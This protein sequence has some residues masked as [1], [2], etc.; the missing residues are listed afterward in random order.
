MDAIKN[1]MCLAAAGMLACTPLIAQEPVDL[2]TVEV[3]GT[4]ASDVSGIESRRLPYR[5]QIL[6]AADFEAGQ[7]FSLPDQL[8]R[9]APGFFVNEAQGN[10]LQ[11]DL[12]FRGFTASP[13]LGLPQGL[14]VYVN[15][16]R[17]NEVFGDTVNFDLL[18][19]DAFGRIE[20]VPGSNP[21]YGLNSLGGAIAIRTKTGFT[22]PG[23]SLEVGGGSFARNWQSLESGGN[24]GRFGYY[25]NLRR[26]DEEG[27]R[28][29]SPTG[30]YQGLGV[31]SFRHD[32]GDLN[33]TLAGADNDLIGNGAI[34]E[35]LAEI[36][37]TAIFTR[38]DRTSNRL[39]FG[40]L[41]GNYFVNDA[42]ELVGNVYFRQ[43]LADSL[44]GDESEFEECEE[45]QN[46]GFLCEEEDDGEEIVLDVGGNPVAF[47]ENREGGA[48][49]TTRTSQRGYGINFQS[50][51]TQPL[52]GRDNR[53]LVGV[54]WDHGQANFEAD[55]ELGRLTDT[56]A[57]AGSGVFAGEPRVRLATQTN[58]IGL[59]LTDTLQL[60][61]RLAL[62]VSGR[63]NFS[64]VQLIDRFGDELS[65]DH[66]FSRFNPAGGFTYDVGS[67]VNFYA[68]YGEST[69]VPTPVELSCADPEQPCRLPNAFLADPPLEQVVAR[70]VEGGLR[71]EHKKLWGG[72]WRWN[73]GYFRTTNDND[74]LFISSGVV[75][76]QGF[77][78]NVGETRREGV[79]LGLEA[80]YGRWRFATAY[81]Y[82]DASFQEDFTVA[83]PNNPRA[84][85][86]GRIP[87]RRG[88]RIPGIPQHLFKFAAEA[89]VVKDA[90]VGLDLLYSGE[91][92][93][94]GDE[95][96]LTAP[97]SDYVVV[98]LRGEYRF[99]R[100]VSL[101]GRLDNVFDEEYE[102]FG[103]YGNA[104]E[105][106]GPRFDGNRFVTPAA[107]RAGWVGVRLRL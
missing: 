18:S 26:F 57:V 83:S 45:A 28:D 10:P 43:N 72:D 15:G 50:I 101:F 38:P 102:T 3:V 96:N 42:I 20:V 85:E 88:D 60:T 36:D 70:T 65:G 56:R 84:D 22:A 75:A 52:A 105:V 9:T 1:R 30:V 100:H 66:S 103:L 7:A 92:F 86:E 64:D 63:Y 25:L 53:L 59:Y 90:T 46:A 34:P 16:V 5:A 55:T 23:H 17:F 106:L 104:E 8:N 78:D 67:G 82:L 11:P 61:D 13:L 71:G 33:L 99:N 77:F 29:F 93:L 48:L 54:G 107:G 76:G 32:R 37:R 68:G 41:D 51:F 21:V 79:E 44:N 40:V 49:N 80:D 2:E 27:F 95:A 62:T 94:R 69:R 89:E 14:S 39:F 87:V 98:N 91:Q 4:S 58:N 97:L 31:F 81:T 47:D 73:A 6:E 12:Q 35:Q 24:D 74:I 19:D